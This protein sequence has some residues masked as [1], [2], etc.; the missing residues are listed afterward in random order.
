MSGLLPAAVYGL[1]VPAG[2]VLVP[3]GTDFPATFRI[4][5]AALDPTAAPEHHANLPENAPPRA[6]LKL[7]RVP[8]DEEDSED[9]DD[10]ENE[11]LDALIN[12]GSDEDSDED[13]AGSGPSDPTKSKAAKLQ[14]LKEALATAEDEDDEDEEMGGVNGK[15]NKGKA[16]AMLEDD[17]EDGDDTGMD[18]YVVCTLDPTSHYQQPL[19]ITVGENES[20]FFK[21]T[22]T[23]TVWLTGNYVI[24]VDDAPRG[25]DSDDEDGMYGYGEDED[26]MDY[27]EDDESD[28]LDDID[29]PRITEVDDDEEP[30]KL[31]AA[32]SKANKK[33]AA[34]EESLDAMIAKA[35]ATNG[36]S[37]KQQKKLKNNAGEAAAAPASKE[38]KKKVQF[39]E[40]L[41]QGP[42]GSTAEKK[43]K[44]E[45]KKQEKKEEKKETKK[46]EDKPATGIRTVQ[47]VTVDDRKAGKGPAAKKGSTVGMRYIGKLENGKVFDSN[48]KGKPFSFKLG[49][50]QVIKGWDIGVEGMAVGGERRL[51]IPAKHAY[52]NQSI[53]GIP[54]NSTLIFDVKLVTID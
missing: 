45:D 27:D 31:I 18:E 4:T 25:L 37:K 43:N 38:D 46:A 53:P 35:D 20:V 17:E 44:K 7:V 19:D 5:M 1:E 24:P 32:A 13:E 49:S 23:H 8:I 33:R 3:A 40:K 9:E 22:G 36:L 41:E 2:D 51:T 28:E 42:T 50:G 54:K 26:E 48:K 14:A 47:G 6:T 30:P 11:E 16:L 52:G 39:A 10:E 21:V 12:G 15:L 34:E 29:D